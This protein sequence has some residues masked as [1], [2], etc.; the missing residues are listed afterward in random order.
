MQ[1]R[2]RGCSSEER[3]VA[4]GSADQVHSEFLTTHLEQT[5]RLPLHYKTRSV[6]HFGKEELSSVVHA[7]AAATFEPYLGL[8]STATIACN[9]YL[10][11]LGLVPGW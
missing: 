7:V 9:D 11:S 10:V 8:P 6:K 5:G 3:G 1:D 4:S 2:R